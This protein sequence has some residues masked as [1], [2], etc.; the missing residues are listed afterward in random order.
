M[1]LQNNVQIKE[2]MLD[3]KRWA[4]VGATAKKD[5]YGYKIW[6]LL[7]EKDYIAYGI[8]PNYDEIDG[9]KIYSS[10]AQLPERVEVVNMLVSPKFGF[11]IL[12]QVKEA[13]IKYVFFQPGSYDDELV[14][15]AEELGLI[16]LTG[17]C[18]YDTLS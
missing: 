6:K 4:I 1:D 13:D 10:L 18:V 9:E 8:N 5:R 3:K 2:E 17:D 7:K 12:D 14:A 15:R 16:Y 11:D